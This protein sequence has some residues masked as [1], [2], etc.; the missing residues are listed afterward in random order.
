MKLPSKYQI[1]DDVA[2]FTNTKVTGVHFQEGKVRYAVERKYYDA[3]LEREVSEYD[4]VDSE[5]VID[6]IN[7]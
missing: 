6:P 5:S 7:P 4:V 3:F 2:V 1:G